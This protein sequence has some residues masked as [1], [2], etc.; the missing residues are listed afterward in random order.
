MRHYFSNPSDGK[1]TSNTGG[2]VVSVILICAVLFFLGPFFNSEVQ[3]AGS[4]LH[5]KEFSHS[6]NNRSHALFREPGNPLLKSEDTTNAEIEEWLASNPSIEV[7]EAMQ[8]MAISPDGKTTTVIV[9][10]LYRT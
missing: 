6:F 3:T 8:S 10:I 4:P 9:R 5:S 2:T 1:N 7:I